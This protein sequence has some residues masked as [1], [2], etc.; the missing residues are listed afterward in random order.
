MLAALGWQQ[1]L[2]GGNEKEVS[3]FPDNVEISEVVN[4]VVKAH[5]MFQI[6]TETILPLDRLPR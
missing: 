5:I 2:N 3:A 6:I 1:N 4:A